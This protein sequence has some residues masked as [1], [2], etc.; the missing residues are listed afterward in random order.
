MSENK[1]DV[2]VVGIGA[3]G[4]VL[5]SKLARAGMN[6]VGFEAGP[7]WDS[8]EDFASDELSMLNELLWLDERLSA[9]QNPIELGRP[10]SGRGVGGGTVHFV[11]YALRFH[12]DDFRTRTVDGVG[13]DWPITYWDL[14]PYYT[15][16]EVFN[17]VSGPTFFPWGTHHGPYPK[18]SLDRACM[19]ETFR[20][21]CERLGVDSTSGPMFIISSPTKDRSACTYRGFCKFG[22]KPKAKSSTLVTYI[23]DAVRHGAKIIPNSMVARVN[24][25]DNGLVKSVT[26]IQDSKELE[27]EAELFI[28]SGYAIET[29]R[30]LLNSKTGKHPDGL[31]N[32]SGLVGK[33]LMVH[34]ADFVIGKYEEM[35]RQYRGPQGL[36]L[37]QAWYTR[38]P[39]D[40]FARGYTIETETLQP[41]EFSQALIKGKGIWGRQLVEEMR[42]YNHYASFGI[43]GEALPSKSNTVTLS[44]E[45]DEYGIPRA[46]VTYSYLDNDKKLI[47]HAVKKCREIHEAAGAIETFHYPATA[48]LLG[49]CRMGKKPETSV[50]DEWCRSHDIPNL[51]VCDGSIFVTGAGV[52]PTL[53]V[54]ALAARTADYIIES[55]KRLEL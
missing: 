45:L 53:T 8:E 19:H 50:V 21:G 43:V 15:E 42:D 36:A 35:I 31:A 11:G 1:V 5:L 7:F 39:G 20:R 23:P 3:A 51:F 13:D 18:R 25:N 27:Q 48:H 37:T 33:N 47:S 2:V 12:E 55:S 26:Y 41:I 14:E 46:K 28:I 22:C 44:D 32:S 4:S 17:Q 49:T 30:L 24:L 54:E 38:K 29:P 9:G 40:G 10:N 16:V 52:N 34:P 6:V